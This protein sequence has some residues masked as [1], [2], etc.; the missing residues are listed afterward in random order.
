M[1]HNKRQAQLQNWLTTVFGSRVV[2]FRPASND[3]SF[4]RYFRL[5]V[6]SDTYVVMDAP[7]DKEDTTPFLRIARRFYDIGLN[8][9]RI[10]ETDTENGFLVMT[11]L[12]TEDYLSNL[13]HE[14]VERFYGDAL[15]ALVVLQTATL[16]EPDFLPDYSEVLLRQEMELFREWYLGK[17]LSISLNAGQHTVL[18]NIFSALVESA[19][20]QP[21]VWVHRDYHSRN[22]MVTK[23]NNPGILDFQDAVLGPVTYD[24]VSLLRDCYIRWPRRQV[25]AWVAGYHQLSR[26]SGIPVCDDE[27]QF[28][29]WF[30]RMGVQRHLKACGIFARLCHRDG[31]T[32]YLD[33]IPRT[34]GYIMQ[35]CH[36]TPELLP[37]AHLIEECEAPYEVT[38]E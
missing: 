1:S 35:V 25:Q 32:G 30:D 34:L 37:L 16:V 19:R 26:H 5:N 31:K 28:T 27:Q 38:D 21:R 2:D 29:G 24:L 22:L 9:P 12:G 4:R 15:D 10:V 36:A 20:E 18:D 3:A 6:G 13:K 8:V 14:T 23:K 17:H 11:D 7:P 33:D